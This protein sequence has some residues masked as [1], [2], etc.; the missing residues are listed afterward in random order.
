MSESGRSE[1]VEIEDL[2]PGQTCVVEVDSMQVLICNVDGEWFGVENRCSHARVPLSEAKLFGC[3][4]ECPVHGARFDVRT[5]DVLC[6][7]ARR[8]LRVFPLTRIAGGVL[9]SLD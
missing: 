8:A 3:E 2:A 1:R 7:P 4:L 6:R 9:I 5:G